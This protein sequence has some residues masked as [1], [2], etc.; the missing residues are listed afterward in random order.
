[1]VASPSD[2][3]PQL[4]WGMLMRAARNDEGYCDT[5]EADFQAFKEMKPSLVLPLRL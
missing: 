4:R 3:T 1:M 5:T 2:K